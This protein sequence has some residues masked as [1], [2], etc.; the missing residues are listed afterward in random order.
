MISEF[1]ENESDE[2]TTIG[3]ISQAA[4]DIGWIVRLVVS[5][6][7]TG[8]ANAEQVTMSFLTP[9]GDISV[10]TKGKGEW[11]ALAKCNDLTAKLRE[12]LHASV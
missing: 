12:L 1:M 8:E 2:P 5:A 6:P 11:V 3:L 9:A 10:V 4:R 7:A